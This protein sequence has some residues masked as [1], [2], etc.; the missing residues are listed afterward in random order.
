[1][2]V[3]FID[4]D[5][6]TYTFSIS[7]SVDPSSTEGARVGF[8]KTDIILVNSIGR[9]KQYTFNYQI[10]EEDGDLWYS[11]STAKEPDFL[12]I[13]PEVQPDYGPDPLLAIVLMKDREALKELD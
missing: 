5:S 13:E 10:I 9:S 3:D 6:D 7:D 11:I 1:M 4:W 8:Y 12:Y 2:D